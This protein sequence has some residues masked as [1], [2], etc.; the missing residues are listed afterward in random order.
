LETRRKNEKGR[1]F[2]GEVINYEINDEGYGT[3]RL[4][5]PEKQ[6][7]IS[8][9]MAEQLQEKLVEA[10]E[11]NL[12]FLIL[13]GVEN[14]MFSAGGDLND[15]H[16][17]LSTSEAFA[18]LKPMMDVLQMVLH[19]PVPVIALLNGNALGG[20]CEL[21]L[22]CDIRIA[23]PNAKFGLPELNLGIIPGAGGTQRL[24]RIIGQ[25]RAL[26]MILT[27][28][29]ID[30]ETALQIGLVKEIIHKNQWKES[31]E[32]IAENIIAKGPVAVQLAKMSVLKGNDLSMEAALLI[33]KL[34]QTISF[35]T[36]DR[37]EG[38]KAFLEKRKPNFA[39][40]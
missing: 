28:E 36:E 6:N 39:N 24:S 31:I 11:A 27:G 29:M 16:G 22:A 13:T 8:L 33:E 40:K 10:R 26:D 32:T 20:G 38:T 7:A 15:L 17:E 2:L 9:H 3:I 4:K 1:I 19:F 12:K 23:S 18:R 5:R 25:G 14:R 21:A 34:A 35:A 37:K 30:A